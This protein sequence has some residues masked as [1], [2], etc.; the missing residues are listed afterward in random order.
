MIINSICQLVKFDLM[1][2]DL[3]PDSK[4]IMR[5]IKNILSPIICSLKAIRLC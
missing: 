3:T 1:P 5:V 4:L 2:V